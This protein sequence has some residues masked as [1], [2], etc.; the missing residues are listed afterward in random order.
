M[1]SLPPLKITCTSTD[2]GNN[3]HCF[4]SARKKGSTDQQ[5]RC[6]SCGV[7]L[8]DWHRVHRRKLDDADHTFASL[9]LEL[10]RH[11]F[12]HVP[13]SRRAI[14]H[15]L[16]KGKLLLR[17]SAATQIRRLIGSA[18]P[19]RDG[20]QTYREDSPRA[21]AIHYAQHATASCCRKCLEEWHGIPQGRELSDDEI[22]YLTSLAMLYVDERIPE[23]KDDPQKVS[24]L[25]PELDHQSHTQHQP[26]G[27]I[28]AA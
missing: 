18:M 26:P 27:P 17:S 21:N 4:R 28:R 9:R 12:W 7:A 5:G 24:A 23:I 22:S 25:R 8:I 19:F 15:A 3:L 1:D 11:Y 2:C 6:R 16:R 20:Y 10:I 14:T 13:I